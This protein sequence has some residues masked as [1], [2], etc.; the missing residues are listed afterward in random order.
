MASGPPEVSSTR[1]RFDRA[2]LAGGGRGGCERWTLNDKSWPDNTI[3]MPRSP[4]AG[5]G[6]AAD[7]PG[8]TLFHCHHPGHIDEGF[9]G[10]VVHA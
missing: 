2:E 1:N 9:A 6:F 4:T 3:S 7:N 10:L 8:H 5:I